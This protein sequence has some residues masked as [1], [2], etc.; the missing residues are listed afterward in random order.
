MPIWL[1][2]G[3]CFENVSECIIH[4]LSTIAEAQHPPFY[5]G[6]D[7]SHR[8]SMS[9]RPRL[10]AGLSGA[11]LTI[12]CQHRTLP[13]W[14]QPLALTTPE[15]DQA[16]CVVVSVW[17]DSCCSLQL[18]HYSWWLEALHTLCDISPHTVM[19]WLSLLPAAELRKIF[20]NSITFIF[21]LVLWYHSN[22]VRYWTIFFLP[23]SS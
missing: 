10:P 23:L 1:Y 12:A 6:F 7:M 22:N 17:L 9:P 14:G 18:R 20:F 3:N 11:N 5:W 15:S 16:R 4:P 19:L 2:Q 8:P 21:L 13:S